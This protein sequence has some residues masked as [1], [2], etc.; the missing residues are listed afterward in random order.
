MK[1]TTEVYKTGKDYT[2]SKLYV[3]GVYQCYIMEDVI[4]KGPKVFGETA[5]PRGIYNI[6]VTMSERFKKL[7]PLLQNVLNFSGV[8]IHPGNTSLNTEGCLLPG[9]DIGEL[10]GKVAVLDSKPAF[11]ALYGKIKAA[12]DRGEKVT[13]ELK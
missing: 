1:I 6:V 9:T 4:R 8:R 5:I 3:D 10:G 2:I 12:L 7:L 11:S 13:I